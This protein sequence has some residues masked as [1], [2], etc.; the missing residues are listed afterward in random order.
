MKINNKTFIITGLVKSNNEFYKESYGIIYNKEAFNEEITD[1]LIFPNSYESKLIIKEKLNDYNIID[2][3]SSVI[4]VVQN[5]VKGVSY[6]LMAFSI[7][8]LIVSIIMIAV[9]S[10]ISV[11]ERTREIGILKSIGA[12]S[13]DIKRLFLSENII[14]GFTIKFTNNKNSH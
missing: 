2:E 9:I 14:I 13:K 10:Y 4:N 3:S 11:I 6:I 5:F 8:S 1:I 12:N 7:I